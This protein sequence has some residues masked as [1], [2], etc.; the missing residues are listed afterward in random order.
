MENTIYI[1][2]EMIGP[3]CTFEQAQAFA[4]K[5][6][7][8][9]YPAKAFAACG[10]IPRGYANADHVPAGVWDAVIRAVFEK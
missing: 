5:L 6:T 4:E 8:A 2:A 1:D 7:E 10:S 3:D 9:G